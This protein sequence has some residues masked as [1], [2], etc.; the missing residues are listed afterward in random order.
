MSQNDGHSYIPSNLE[1]ERRN[2]FLAYQLAERQLLD[3]TARA[4]VITHYLKMG[5]PREQIER[6]AMLAKIAYLEGQLEACRR[7]VEVLEMMT[8]AMEALREY[9]GENPY[10]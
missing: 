2:A 1:M 4:Q 8:Q 7:D 6:D 10:E 5:S 9:R 3:G